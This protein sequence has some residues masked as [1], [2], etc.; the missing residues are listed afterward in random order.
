MQPHL[1]PIPP[2]ALPPDTTTQGS[3]LQHRDWGNNSVLGVFVEVAARQTCGSHPNDS[4]KQRAVTCWTAGGT[5]ARTAHARLSWG[6]QALG[7][8]ATWG[9]GRCRAP[10][11]VA[12]LCCPDFLFLPYKHPHPKAARTICLWRTQPQSWSCA[13][14]LELGRSVRLWWPLAEVVVPLSSPQLWVDRK[15]LGK[16]PASRPADA[17]LGDRAGCGGWP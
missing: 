15:V 7:T 12:R 11:G 9:T 3:G 8:S 16:G 6:V 5:R 10:S 13:A 14:G 4:A 2:P 1:S 17:G